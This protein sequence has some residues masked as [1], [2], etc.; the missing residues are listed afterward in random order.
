MPVRGESGLL[1]P[2]VQYKKMKSKLK[3][4]TCIIETNIDSEATI[5]ICFIQVLTQCAL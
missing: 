2:I 4:F 3:I 5:F 1:S